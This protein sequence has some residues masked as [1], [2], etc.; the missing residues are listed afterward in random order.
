[1]EVIINYDYYLK[2]EMIIYIKYFYAIIFKLVEYH[3]EINLKHMTR[4]LNNKIRDTYYIMIK[5][6]RNTLLI[7]L[8]ITK[9]INSGLLFPFFLSWKYFI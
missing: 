4:V 2:I 8:I 6:I 3:F 1:M 7:L 5:K 9:N